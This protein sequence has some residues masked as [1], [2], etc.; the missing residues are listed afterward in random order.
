MRN[1]IDMT[2]LGRS[3]IGFEHLFD[4][5]QNN[6]EAGPADSYPPYNIEKAAEDRYRVTLAVAGFSEDE[7][8]VT[9]EPNRLTVT[10]RKRT[11]ARSGDLLYQGIA[12][13]PFTR[14][15]DLADHVFVRGARLANGLLTI[16]LEREIP[17]AMKP[18]RIEIGAGRT[19][20]AAV[21][22]R[23]A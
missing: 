10:G 5:L 18:R 17:E 20:A 12:G 15:F 22:K 2:A 21:E 4:M 16:E 6:L 19:E 11:E 1:T 9:S 3:A 23:A 7:L 8:E 14:H 13:R